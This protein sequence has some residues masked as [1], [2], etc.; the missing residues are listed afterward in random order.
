MHNSIMIR[1]WTGT[2][3]NFLLFIPT[4]SIFHMQWYNYTLRKLGK[5]NY[6]FICIF[7]LLIHLAI[8]IWWNKELL[9]GW[10]QNFIYGSKFFTYVSM[11]DCLTSG[12]TKHAS[13]NH[14]ICTVLLF[15]I[16][17]VSV[18]VLLNCFFP[19]SNCLYSIY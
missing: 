4:Y 16:P 14:S 1:I 6:I 10:W 18:I 15:S 7:I 9:I 17:P 12:N 3:S 5:A 8:G 13:W 2:I 19:F 11:Y